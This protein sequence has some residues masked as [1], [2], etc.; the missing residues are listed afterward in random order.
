MIS[1]R[2]NGKFVLVRVQPH[3][4]EERAMARAWWIGTNP[5]M[6]NRPVQERECYSC[7]WANEKFLGI[8]YK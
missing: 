4:S 6:I 3:E 8:K 7:M 5:D 1:V 2:V